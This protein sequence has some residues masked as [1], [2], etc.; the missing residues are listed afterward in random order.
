LTTSVPAQ[1]IT[2]FILATDAPTPAPWL[3]AR[4]ANGSNNFD[5]WI[6]GQSGQSYVLQS[7]SDFVNWAAVQTNTLITNSW[8]GVLPVAQSQSTFYRLQQS[9]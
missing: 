3:Q 1:S 8:H 6:N 7:T 4:P 5:L 2:L 9:P